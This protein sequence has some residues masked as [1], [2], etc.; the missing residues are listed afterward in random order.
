MTHGEDPGPETHEDSVVLTYLEGLLMHPVELGSGATAGGR[1]EG[2]HHN[3]EQADQHRS[4]EVAAPKAGANAPALGSSQHLK[5]ARLLQ[6]GAWNHSLAQPM[7]PPAVDLK[8]RGVDLRNGSPE[9][10]G[11]A[12]ESTLLASLLQSFSSRL[13]SV[14]MSQQPK[15]PSSECSSPA[16][17]PAADKDSLRLY[18]SATGHLKGLTRKSKHRNR[19]S[20][21]YSHRGHGQDRAPESPKAVHRS[22]PPS[23]SST[24]ESVSCAER[25]KAVANMVKIRSSPAASPK[26]S[27]A[28]SQLAL[29]LS[30]EAHFQQYS[31]V[32]ALK[33]RFP[34]RC[35]SERLAAIANQQQGQDQR[36]P[37]AGRAQSPMAAPAG[38]TSS[39]APKL[40]RGSSSP[41]STCGLSRGAPSQPPPGPNHGPRE[42]RSLDSRPN[43]PPQTC[44]SLLLLLLNNHSGQKQLTRNGHLEERP[45]FLPL[46]CSSSATSDSESSQR[47]R[48]SA[49]DSSDGESCHSR[50]S[51]MDLSVRTRDA[52]PKASSPASA[53]PPPS[54]PMSSAP[55]PFSSTTVG[56]TFSP[57]SQVFSSV[58][59]AISSSSSSSLLTSSLDKLTESL[60]S[61]WKPEPSAPKGLK[62]TEPEASSE[63][64]LK[65]PPKVTLMQLLLERRNLEMTQK[66]PDEQ[67]PRA[68]VSQAVKDLA[69]GLGALKGGR[70]RSPLD[71]AGAPAQALYSCSQYPGSAL[72]SLPYLSPHMQSSPLDLCTSKSMSP[73]LSPQPAFSASKMLQNLAQ[74]SCS[75]SPPSKGQAP[76]LDARRPLR[77]VESPRAAGRSPS[78]TPLSDRPSSRGTP[79]LKEDLLPSHIENL[80]EKRTVLQLLLGT[81]SQKTRLSGGRRAPDAPGGHGERA[82]EGASDF[83]PDLSPTVKKE[84]PAAAE[85]HSRYG[86]LSQLLK[87]QSAAYYSATARPV[88]G[89]QFLVPGDQFHQARLVP[90]HFHVPGDKFHIPSPKKR[91]LCYGQADLCNHVSPSAVAEGENQPSFFSSPQQPK[92]KEE[93]VLLPTA[94]GLSRESQGFNVLKKLLL[95]DN[96]LKELSQRVQDNA[97]PSAS[98]VPG[99]SPSQPGLRACPPGASPT[100]GLPSQPEGLAPPPPGH[101][102]RPQH[103]LDMA[104]VVKQ[105]PRSAERWPGQELE[106]REALDSPQLS[107]SNPILYYMLQKGSVHL[108]RELREPRAAAERSIKEESISP[109]HACQ[110]SL[111]PPAHTQGL[112]LKHSRQSRGLS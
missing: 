30:S 72:A 93:E 69:N 42:K 104:A 58:S 60:I 112:Q 88:P 109:L 57:C 82:E 53:F 107:R 87:Q 11:G 6:S 37:S 111:S 66:G 91:R 52:A 50:C 61:K 76:E 96:C 40:L 63:L 73:E 101:V 25:L 48:S 64:E 10:P 31:Q 51:P 44:S 2:V 20:A 74:S 23:A 17:A 28:C 32:H 7:N 102:L 83:V 27:V 65:S 34:G 1:S 98:R 84:H 41:P 14:A 67:V 77:P 36:P 92:V 105:E 49:K 68:S 95:S 103:K 110:R 35:A 8:G 71:Q 80:L 97:N 4:H 79:S 15:P 55:L 54:F 3:Q 99:A 56:K 21:P 18:D 108:N 85:N 70:I 39:L 13:Q 9:V 46:S 43:R 47:D 75:A 29:L 33:A 100:S 94:E 38:L 19:S 86:L 12:G 26:P 62:D 22:T 59:A 81:A 45:G 90:E 106:A 24:G 89:D 78:T 5:K 16:K